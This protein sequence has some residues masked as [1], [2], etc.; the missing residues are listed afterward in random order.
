MDNRGDPF[1]DQD[2]RP[3]Y[4]SRRFGRRQ[5][6][7]GLLRTVLFLVVGAV[8]V[9][10]LGWLAWTWT[11]WGGGPAPEADRAA[12]SDT[13]PAGGGTSSGEEGRDAAMEPLPPLDE[14]DPVVRRLAEGIS[15]RP[16]VASWFVSEDLV[17]RFVVAVTNVANGRSPEE[18]VDFMEVEGD[19]Q[20][21]TEGDRTV[22]DPASYRRYDGLVTAFVSLDPDGSAELYRRL[23][24]L[25][26][27]AYRDL[28]LG[29]EGFDPVLA[30]AVQN[31]LA[32]Q[33]PAPPVE[34]RQ[35]E[36]VYLYADPDLE[37][38]TAA[39]KHLLRM[40]PENARRVQEK[41]RA[42]AAAL[43]LDVAGAGEG[44]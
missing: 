21:R 26:D 9:G 43:E 27:E 38:G 32:V 28:G 5:D 30:R 3:V 18:Q 23:R 1:D 14:S 22:V 29:G 24:P 10:G 7:S 25:F 41:L 33:L 35:D 42:L 20:V 31:V 6:R 19:F 4:S 36:G 8:V 37:A 13:I 39:R 16:R 17:R 11:G 15:S 34:V 12:A 2:G 40:G 44:G